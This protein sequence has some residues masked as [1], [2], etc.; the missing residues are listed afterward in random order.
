MGG[1]G[2]VFPVVLLAFSVVMMTFVAMVEQQPLTEADTGTFGSSSGLSSDC[3]GILSILSCIGDFFHLI[4]N[5]MTFNIPGAPWWIRVPF[6][7]LMIGPWIFV[8]IVLIVAV[9]P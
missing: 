5:V 7:I 9:I 6:G 8:I 3:S 1:V 4:F 2:I